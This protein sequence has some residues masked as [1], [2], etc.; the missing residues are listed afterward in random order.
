MSQRSKMKTTQQGKEGRTLK[1]EKKQKLHNIIIVS[2]LFLLFF[3]KFGPT[4][5]SLS[6]EGTITLVVA[7]VMALFW[8]FEPIPI[9]ATA[10]MPLAV[11]P[12]FN[13]DTFK[14]VVSNYSNSTI[15]LFLG[16]FILALAVETTGLHKRLSL[17]IIRTVGSKPKNIIAGFILAPGLLSMWI[18]NTATTILMLPIAISIITLLEKT[19]SAKMHKTMSVAILLSIAF[20]ASLGGMATFIGTPPNAIFSAFAKDNNIEIGFGQF[21]TIGAPLSLGGLFI[22]WFLFTK[23]LFKLD[24]HNIEGAKAIL[25]EEYRKLPKMTSAEKKVFVVFLVTAFLWIFRSMADDYFS[26]I[27]FILS[28][29]GIAMASAMVL[30]FLTDGKGKKIMTWEKTMHLPWGILLLFGGGLA[31]GAQIQQTGVGIW[32]AATLQ[33]VIVLVPPFLIVGLITI[34]AMVISQ[35]VS[36]TATTAALLPIFY[37]IAESINL[38]P[39]FVMLPLTFGASAVFLLPSATPPNAMVLSGGRLE[40]RDMAKYGAILSIVVTVFIVAITFTFLKYN[41]GFDTGDGTF[42]YF[43]ETMRSSP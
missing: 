2:S 42:E 25:D 21:M 13:I 16:G 39:L 19:A 4:L 24:E 36:N 43:V 28:D 12:L 15:S 1:A 8:V 6:R 17:A 26:R 29:P 18:S 20:S 30:F 40:V 31:L 32:I 10:L 23:V 37:P 38:H 33:N 14:S 5:G 11:F 35:I 9:Y 27:G 41:I 3:T 22:L 7:V 34:A